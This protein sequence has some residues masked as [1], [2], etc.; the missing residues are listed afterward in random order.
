M[1]P[2]AIAAI[3]MVQNQ[4]Q[5]PANPASPISTSN[6]AQWLL[7]GLTVF[8]STAIVVHM[9]YETRLFRLQI[10]KMNRDLKK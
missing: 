5:A 3:P 8:L 4:G 7:F 2:P 9:V 6:K 1:T 10:E